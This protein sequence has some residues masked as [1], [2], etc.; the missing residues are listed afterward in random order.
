MP[1]NSV[2]YGLFLVAVVG[3]YWLLPRRFRRYLLLIASYAF[4]AA[5]DWRFLSLIVFSTATDFMVGR[6]LERTDDQSRRKRALLLS[7][8]VNIGLLAIFK[9]LSFFVD[10]AV[11]ALEALGLQPNVTSL[12]IILPVGISFYTFQTLSYSIDVYRRKTPAVHNLVTFANFVAFFPQLVAGPIERASH[13]VPQ[14]ADE[15]RPWSSDNLAGGLGLIALGLFKKVAIA[16][17]AAQAANAVFAA[18]EGLGTATLILGVY[19]FAMQ[20]YGDFSGYTDIARGSARLFGIQLSRNFTQP[21]LSRSITEFWHRWHIT[22]SS[23]LR[24]YLYI[25]LGGNRRGE[26]RTYLNLMLTMLLGGLWH[27]AAWTFVWWGGIHGSALAF[28][29]KFLRPPHADEPLRWRNIFRIVVTFNLVCLA[30]IFFRAETFSD[31]WAILSGIITLSSGDQLAAVALV[32]LICAVVIGLDLA[33]RYWTSRPFAARSPVWQG[34]V[35]AV[36]VVG[37]LLAAGGE[38]TAFIYFQF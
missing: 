30:W 3:L 21:Y 8:S 26:R 28:E 25:P 32:P 15:S 9:Y 33:G 1:F 29:R 12:T 34:L 38:P 13:L 14:L 27:G 22:L 5:W 2:Q 17:V 10:S 6:Y 35:F 19:A 4:Y 7:I 18:P 11:S 20:I 37:V 31:A 16:D 24:D 23:W 36:A